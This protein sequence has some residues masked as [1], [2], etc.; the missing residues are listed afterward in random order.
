M[1][2]LGLGRNVIALGFVSFFTD[3]SSEMIYPLLPVF[4]TTTLGSGAAFLGLIEGAAE[5]LA[6]LL[7]LYSGIR[8]DRVANRTRLVLWGY[9]LSSISRP[10][11][12]LARGPWHVFT[13]RLFD[14]AGKGI[15]TSPRDALIADSVAPEARGKAFGFHRSMD[16]A[17][18]MVGPI[19]ATLLLAFVFKN[20]LRKVFLIAAVPAA[21]A[22]LVILLQVRD[23]GAAKEARPAASLSLELP[24]G[25]LRT[26]LLILFIFLLSNSSDAFLLL[27]LSSVGVA[28]AVIPLLWTALHVVKASTT[29]P[30]GMLS[31]RLGRRRV[32]LT[33]WIIYA[34]IYAAFAFVRTPIAASAIFIGYGLFYGFTDGV[35]KALMADLSQP[36]ERGRAFGWYHC[37]E[38]LT[39]LPASLVFGFLWQKAGP[40]TAF[41]YGAAL[42]AFA[43]V[44]LALFIRGQAGLGRVR[45]A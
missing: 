9:S 40:Q 38:G 39:L 5:S 17:G 8:S 7:K 36:G 11:V 28:P 19:V 30:L 22:V 32:I 25:K 29:L 10:L 15:R 44:L 26:Y 6:A 35:E 14:R 45:P 42:A 2:R 24:S 23:P 31:D 43:C 20:D 41:L 1:K 12:A 21:C 33:G 3:V 27:R 13:V 16:H 37:V 34:L 4:L 18:A